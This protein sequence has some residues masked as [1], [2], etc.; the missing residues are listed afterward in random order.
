LISRGI[1]VPEVFGD[2]ALLLP[3]LTRGRFTATFEEEAILI[4]NML[5]YNKS[6]ID[7]SKMPVPVVSP[8]QSWNKVIQR[9]VSS[10]M[11]VSSSLHGLIAAEAFGIPARYVRLCEKETLFKYHDYFEGTG[12]TLGDFA[13]S[14]PEALEMGGK[15]PL[16][17]DTDKLV[18]SFPYD[19]W[20]EEFVS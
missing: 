2:P 4:P 5:D 11:V 15:E 17:F 1:Q 13:R 9:I 10:K 8:N 3:I 12:R 18:Q 16:H 7:F 20:G 14:V 6:N 19:I